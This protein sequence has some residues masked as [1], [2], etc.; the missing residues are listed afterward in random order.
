[1]RAYRSLRGRRTP[2]RARSPRDGGIAPMELE[3]GE[4]T[5]IGPARATVS[6]GRSGALTRTI[7]VVGGTVQHSKLKIT[8]QG[9]SQRNSTFGSSSTVSYGIVLQNPSPSEDA[10]DVTV[11]VNFLDGTGRVLESATTDVSR[12]PRR[13]RST[14]A[15]R[16]PLDADPGGAPRDRRSDRLVHAARAS[17]AGP[18]ERRDRH[19]LFDPNWVDSVTGAVVND[20]PT[21][22]L[23]Y[24]RLSI[25]L[26]DAAGH[27]VGGGTGSMFISLPPGTRAF[28]SASRALG[29]SDRECVGR[30]NLDHADVQG[31]RRLGLPRWPFGVSYRRLRHCWRSRSRRVRA[32]TRGQRSPRCPCPSSSIPDSASPSPPASAER[33]LLRPARSF[34]GRDAAAGHPA[35]D[36]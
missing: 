22:V 11:L 19:R 34:R 1:M 35:A 33:P 13:A 20:H 23:T 5:A 25:V 36:V 4:T 21:D 6:C 8:N 29:D 26:F 10:K 17:P 30:C 24:A 12:L 32:R 18:G 27:V 14:S 2:G 28:F 9:F 31:A 7:T 15:T 16:R 3:R